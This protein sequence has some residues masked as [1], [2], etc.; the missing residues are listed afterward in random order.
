M[1]QKHPD[2]GRLRK[3]GS[4]LSLQ[5]QEAGAMIN[6]TFQS[7][8][9]DLAT[10]ILVISLAERLWCKNRSYFFPFAL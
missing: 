1:R 10:Q 7:Q 8:R 3:T 9:P 6:Q 4:A 5:N 2:L